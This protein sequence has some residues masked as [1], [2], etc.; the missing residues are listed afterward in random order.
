MA[1]EKTC[2]IAHPSESTLPVAQRLRSGSQ[3]ARE[4]FSQYRDNFFNL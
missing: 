4:I 3:F 2:K 1:V